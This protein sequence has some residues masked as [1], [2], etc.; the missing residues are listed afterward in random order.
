LSLL[1]AVC[2]AAAVA[3]RTASAG[4][5][6]PYSAADVSLFDD[7][8]ADASTP[9][10]YEEQFR[11]GAAMDGDGKVDK[12]MELNANM[13]GPAEGGGSG[14]GK[15]PEEL[16]GEATPKGENSL[17]LI[18]ELTRVLKPGSPWRECENFEHAQMSSGQKAALCRLVLLEECERLN[19]V[20][21]WRNFGAKKAEVDPTGAKP[22]IAAANE[23]GTITLHRIA[24]GVRYLCSMEQEETLAM[25]SCTQLQI[26]A[27]RDPIAMKVWPALG[28]ETECAVPAGMPKSKTTSIGKKGDEKGDKKKK[29]GKKGDDKKDADQKPKKQPKKKD[30][31]RRY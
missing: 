14:S 11:V 20:E 13:L 27:R 24:D 19:I 15:G 12:L 22:T 31:F 8:D 6:A 21:R 10:D 5:A 7:N 25:C 16:A 2:C 28:F 3:T 9:N 23:M 4:W 17:R 30:Y 1:L 26:I 29:G 18:L